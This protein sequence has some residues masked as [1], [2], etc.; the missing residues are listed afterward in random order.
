MTLALQESD[1]VLITGATGWFGRTA[2][3]LLPKHVV[4]LCTAS[5]ARQG[6]IEY[7]FHAVREFA[8]TV[9][10]NFAFLTREKLDTLGPEEFKVVNEELLQRFQAVTELPSVRGAVTVSSGAAIT[11][12][13]H[14]YG[15]L[16]NREE[17]I[18]LSFARSKSVNVIRA[19]SVSGGMVL[20]PRAYA[21]SDFILQAES[22][23]IRIRADQP[24]FRRYVSVAD[25]LSLA[26]LEVNSG[27][28][29][30]VETG[31]PLVEM[32]ELAEVIRLMVNPTA[33]IDRVP[34]VSQ[35]ESVY[36]SDGQSWD[37]AC[38]RH[39]Y[40]PAT[41]EQQITDVA[42]SLRARALHGED[43]GQ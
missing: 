17:E 30:V 10:L 29:G 26:I 27:H 24:T 21:F 28:S 18:A 33:V 6:C 22:G 25:A 13:E 3:Q 40:V 42:E 43:L 39:G 15:E 5:S 36:A 41:L 35:G 7:S 37:E 34:L 8:P 11:E 32:Q 31:G 38:A 20:R 12:P 14:P 1:R 9:V 4:R 19:Y 23:S 16:K 2:Q